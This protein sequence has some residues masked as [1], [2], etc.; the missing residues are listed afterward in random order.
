MLAVSAVLCSAGSTMAS[1]AVHST[2]SFQAIA[3]QC[4]R[5]AFDCVV[6][7]PDLDLAMSRWGKVEDP[8][9]DCKFESANDTLSIKVP[10]TH[11]ALNPAVNN[12]LAPRVLNDVAGNFSIEVKV[13]CFEPPASGSSTNPLAPTSSL[14]GSGILIWQDEKNFFRIMQAAIGDRQRKLIQLRVGD[15]L[16]FENAYTFEAEYLHLKVFRIGRSFGVSV[17]EDGKRWLLPAASTMSNLYD[18]TK[19]FGDEVR[20]GVV[21]VNA[22]NQEIQGEFAELKISLEPEYAIHDT[23]R[24]N[25]EFPKTPL[26]ELRDPRVQ[27]DL[28]LKRELLAAVKALGTNLAQQG[29]TNDQLTD[30]L[31]RLEALD[32][33]KQALPVADRLTENSQPAQDLSLKTWA[34]V[35]PMLT[36]Q[37]TKRLA[38]LAFQRF[39]PRSLLLDI[40]QEQLNLD[41][42]QLKSIENAR[43][44]L[45]ESVAL[46]NSTNTRTPESELKYGEL[47]KQANK[48]LTEVARHASQDRLDELRG[49]LFSFTIP[50]MVAYEEFVGD[51]PLG[52]LADIIRQPAVQQE[53]KLSGSVA[54]TIDQFLEVKS[55]EVIA[56]MQTLELDTSESPSPIVI[57]AWEDAHRS[58]DNLRGELELECRKQLTTQQNSRLQQILFQALG[59][60][61]LLVSDSAREAL[62]LTGQ[63]R[64]DLRQ[65][66]ERLSKSQNF[67]TLMYS[68]LRTA[69]DVIALLTKQQLEKLQDLKGAAFYS[70]PISR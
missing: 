64:E 41:E 66:K 69:D 62:E 55:R 32:A 51:H 43:G 52:P 25:W 9:S 53:L 61:S 40:V 35:R 16:I 48:L 2:G 54:D 60:H 30:L 65:I 59:P 14:V 33:Q 7:T 42:P 15:R 26:A 19:G 27:Q 37:Q 34:S 18:A 5:T 3:G 38:G 56:V 20:A 4:L 31:A 63:Q 46:R 50:G 36:E 68:S 23:F 57:K 21:V 17:S 49:D 45:E 6:Q 29:I 44:L 10:G 11:H 12:L 8:A 58:M 22:I 13:K 24:E 28:Q 39:G 67:S 1:A 47:R 70:L